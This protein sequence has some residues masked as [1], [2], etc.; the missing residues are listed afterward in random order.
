MFYRHIEQFEGAA[1]GTSS[2]FR[3]NDEPCGCMRVG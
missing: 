3:G 1:S 2:P